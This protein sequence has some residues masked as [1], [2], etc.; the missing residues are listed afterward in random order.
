MAFN[1][2]VVDFGGSQQTRFYKRPVMSG[3][4]LKYLKQLS[5]DFARRE[6]INEIE[7]FKASG[8]IPSWFPVNDY[9]DGKIKIENIHTFEYEEIDNSDKYA[10]TASNRSKKAIYE[11]TRSN[12]WE[13]FFTV[14]F[15]PEDGFDRYD[16]D[17][18]Y[19]KLSRWLNNQ[20]LRKAPDLKY[21]FVPEEHKDGAYHFHGLVSNIGSLT[22]QDSHRRT[23]DGLIIYNCLDWKNGYTTAT[24]VKD[25][26]RVAYYVTKYI[27]KEL[28]DHVKGR[29]RYLCSKNLNRPVITDLNL[30]DEEQRDLVFKLDNITYTKSLDSFYNK[31]QYIESASS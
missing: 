14:T 13:Y 19:K 10:E 9:I 30:S 20:R 25:T 6:R 1:T 24:E 31:V 8:G 28:C 16:Y 7:R 11:L 27:T 5:K 22:L 12:V 18:C 23:K 29:Q 4:E 21:L 15:R 3:D 26:H 17:A 2:K